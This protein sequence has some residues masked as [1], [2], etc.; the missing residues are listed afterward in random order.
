MEIDRKKLFK[1]L[2]YL[3][4]FILIL[5]FTAGKFYWY[6]SIPYLDM[7]MHF[8]GGFWLGL[9]FVWLLAHQ[10]KE[11]SAGFIL[12][13]LS[14]VLFIGIGWEIFE[15]LVNDVIT[16]NPFNFGDTFSDLFFDLLGGFCAI[17]YLWKKLHK[18]QTK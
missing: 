3:I 16:K 4:F 17:L 12:K 10:V 14:C 5:N 2:A 1:T 6:S 11:D 7:I 13:I 9:A 18:K 8:L 15:I